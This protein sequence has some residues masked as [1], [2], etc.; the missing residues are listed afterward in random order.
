[1]TFYALT[2]YEQFGITSSTTPTYTVVGVHGVAVASR[3]GRFVTRTAK[4]SK[5]K[6]EQPI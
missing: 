6:Q 4:S 2:Y 1:M 5:P 3:A